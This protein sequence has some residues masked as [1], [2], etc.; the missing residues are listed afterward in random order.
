MLSKCANPEC[1]TPFLYMHGGRLFRWDHT[2]AS[3]NTELAAPPDFKKRSNKV[4]FFWLCNDC[5]S[6][7]T[8]IYREGVGVSTEKLVRTYKVAS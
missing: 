8:L 7:M 6:K 1:S 4:E 2:S 3:K 5:A